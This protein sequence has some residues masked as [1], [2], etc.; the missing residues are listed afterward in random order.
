MRLRKNRE[1]FAQMNFLK[2]REYI[3]NQYALKSFRVS[4]IIIALIWLLTMLNIFLIDRKITTSCFI[5][6]VVVYILGRIVCKV[7]DLSKPWIKYFIILWVVVIITIVNTFLTYHAA[8]ACL[9]PIVYTTMYSS[10]KMMVYTYILTVCSI[11]VSVFV[12]YHIGICD[13]NMVLLTGKSLSSYIGEDGTFTL[14][15]IN[16]NLWWTLTLFY[17]VP[18]SMICAA[19]T[20]VCA[21]INKI[22]NLNVKYAQKMENMAEIDGMT[23]LY[24]KSKYMDVIS[25][26]YRNEERI[27]VI[28]WDINYLKVVNDTIGHE[29]GDRLI[30]TVAESIRSITSETDCGYRVGGDEF[31]LIMRGGDEKIVQRKIQEWEKSLE[32]LTKNI[33]FPISVSTGFAFGT[34]E[35]LEK[36]ISKADKMMYENKRIMHSEMDKKYNRNV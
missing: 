24:N 8:L 34:G 7:N 14:T 29:A 9:L 21:N 25:G 3:S 11:I 1:D 10:K 6:C 27:A 23:G 26:M 35:E 15:Q 5:S 28:F 17:V 31:I 13:A 4:I 33:E 36:I 22:I 32:T 12:G 19:L 16:N 20:V 30:L 18:R 2:N